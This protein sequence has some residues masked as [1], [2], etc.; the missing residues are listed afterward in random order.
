MSPKPTPEAL[1][2]SFGITHSVI[3]WVSKSIKGRFIYKHNTY[4]N[5]L[6]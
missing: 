1:N 5:G 6:W 2:R 3:L 4:N